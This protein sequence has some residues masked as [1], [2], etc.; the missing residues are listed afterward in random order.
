MNIKEE[1]IRKV[2][3]EVTGIEPSKKEGTGE[4][5]Y[6]DRYNVK[7]LLILSSSYDY[8]LLEEEGRL[9]ELFQENFSSRDFGVIPNLSHVEDAHRCLDIIEKSRIDLLIVINEPEMDIIDF[10]KKVKKSDQQVSIVVLGNDTN[11]LQEISSN[12]DEDLMEGVFTWNGD[13]KI[14]LSIVQYLEDRRNLENGTLSENGSAVLLIEDSIQ[15]Y[16]SYL[17]IVYEEI[18]KYMNSILENDL[19]RDVKMKRYW[20]RPF[21]L[22][23]KDIDQGK[24]Y[25]QEYRENI[26]CLITDNHCGSPERREEHVGFSF[27]VEVEKD[28]PEINI[29]LQS[30]EPIEELP[31]ESRI[32]FVHK[33]SPALN[34]TVGDFIENC[35]GPVDLVIENEHGVEI[36]SV[37]TVEEF[38]KVL[39]NLEVDMLDGL[40]EEKEIQSWL[41]ARMEY[42]LAD[43]IGSL[44]KIK[45]PEKKRTKLLRALEEHK[46]GVETDVISSFKSREKKPSAKITRIGK[47]ALGGKARGL[48]FMAKI[49]SKYI[50]ED[51]FENLNITIPRSIVLSTDVYE[52]FLDKN[53][54]IFPDIEIMSDDRISSK[55]IDS[56]L[57][58]TVLGDIRSFIRETRKPIIVR[59]SGVLEDSMVQPFAGIYSSML[60]PNESW[61]T[62]LRFQEVCNAIKQVYASTFFERARTYLKS[63][64]KNIGDEKMGVIIQEVVGSKHENYFYPTIS[65]VAK[66]YSHYPSGK[67]KP[68]DGIVYLAL[69][70]GKAIVEGG[71]TYCFCPKHPKVPLTGTPKDYMKYAQ[72]KFYAID[73]E[74]V[75]KKVKKNEETS[76]VELGLKKAEQHDVLDKVVST[77]SMEN[78]RLYPGTGY[79]GSRIVDFAPIINYGDI[80]LAKAIDTLLMISEI[81]LGYPVEIE[82]ALNL[83]D[84]RGKPSELIILQIRSMMSQGGSADVSLEEYDLEELLCRSD[85]ALGNGVI[86]GIRDIVYVDPSEFEMENS[87]RAVEQIRKK[88]KRFVDQGVK[89]LLVGPGRW[90][91][92]DHWLGIPVQWSDIAGAKVIIETPTK[93]RHIEPSQGSHF[94]HDMISAQAG[95]LI[96]Q[97]GEGDVDWGWLESQ[98]SVGEK[99]DIKHV[100]TEEPVEVRIDGKSGK[101]IV[102]KR[103]KE[104][105]VN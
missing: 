89:Y 7:N 21:L 37:E 95:Y 104:K 105:D 34:A 36:A 38:E 74:S 49:L 35:I 93:D 78:D 75:Y 45:D 11:E 27:A 16:S 87:R 94:F 29:L 82:F 71:N 15:Y 24:E 62:D 30:S 79:D 99:E 52:S 84:K 72:R 9:R 26:Q 43:M 69:G 83:G 101:G 73:L 18:W 28:D 67:C 56:S 31:E 57:P 53:D 76:I 48:A 17:P 44:T 22:L 90:G 42:Q 6:F 32:Q 47:G 2:V 100:K 103:R 92:S 40:L 46:Y 60:L 81:A 10:S 14:I 88:N 91:T 63:T 13:G 70:L 85:N 97:K 59:S 39:W 51:M 23:A 66:S 68:E 64:T 65:G 3:K 55:F 19:P 5:R 4:E 58:A 98:E 20:S 25:Y 102:I 54:L 50:T 96:T 8:F 86:E 80:P 77:Y 33:R 61:E 1:E 41:R 12:V